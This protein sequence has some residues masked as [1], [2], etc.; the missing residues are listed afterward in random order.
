[1]SLFFNQDTAPS[2]LLPEQG[3][4]GP[5]GP[6]GPQGP[7]GTTE[8][9]GITGK[10]STF[11]P[12]AHKSTHAIGG[13][14][15]LTPADIGAQ[16]QLAFQDLITPSN[17]TIISLQTN[18]FNSFLKSQT[19]DFQLQLPQT[20]TNGDRVVVSRNAG[21]STGLMT[22]QRFSNGGWQDLVSLTSVGQLAA[23]SF[24]NGWRRE[25]PFH[26]HAIADITGL[27]SALDFSTA[28]TSAAAPATSG[29][30]GSAGSVRYDGDYIYI[31][32]AT[33]TWRR[34]AVT[35]W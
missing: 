27:Q 31:C 20:A 12:S 5:P 11:A 1:M 18:T 19:P 29:S 24:F 15:A 26:T 13:S 30:I 33:N 2:Q 4:P 28:I 35:S 9:D 8:W 22:I 7:A 3:P 16:T 25:L 6:T 21:T 34:T 10:P 32:T 17:T 14:D 23:F